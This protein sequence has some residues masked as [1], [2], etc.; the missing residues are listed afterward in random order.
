MKL[1]HLLP[2]LLTATLVAGPLWGQS[3]KDAVPAGRLDVAASKGVGASAVQYPLSAKDLVQVDSNHQLLTKERVR[4]RV[5]LAGVGLRSGST[6]LPAALW[7][8]VDSGGWEM[9]YY[10]TSKDLDA[11]TYLVDRIVEKNRVINLAARG[12]DTSGNWG[13]ARLTTV[14]D[15]AIASLVDGEFAAAPSQELI[16]S[17]LTQFITT[18]SLVALGSR[19]ILYLFE[20]ESRDSAAREF[21][22]QDLVLIVSLERAN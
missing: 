16:K 18:D 22:M 6:D 1:H 3:L 15:V 10:G 7:V 11:E 13:E 5:R 9:L 2:G 14:P 12:R 8:Q 19:E 4:L 20:L 21:D 17:F